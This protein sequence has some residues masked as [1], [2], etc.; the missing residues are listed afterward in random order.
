[1]VDHSRKE[2]TGLFHT[3]D[4]VHAHREGSEAMIA[5]VVRTKAEQVFEGF[6]EFGFQLGED[7]GFGPMEALQVLHPL[8]VT[9]GDPTGVAQDIGDKEDITSFLDNGI[10][11]RGGGTVGCLGQ[12]PALEL[13]GV[14]LGDDSFKS[15]RDEDVTLSSEHFLGIDCFGFREPRHPAG[16]S[17]MLSQLVG[18]E[19]VVI[20]DRSGNIGNPAHFHPIGRHGFDGIGTDIPESLHDG[21]GALN[22]ESGLVEGAGGKEGDAVSRGLGA[23]FTSLKIHGLPGNDFGNKATGVGRIGIED[24]RHVLG[25]GADIGRHDI[26]FRS[27]ERRDFLGKATGQTFL[28]GHAELARVAGDAALAASVGKIHERTFPVHPHRQSGHFANL[29]L[30]VKTNTAFDGATGKV[31]LDTVAEKNLGAT[32]VHV[33][34]QAESQDSFGPFATFPDRLVELE[35]IG[36]AVKLPGGHTED[37]VV[38]EL[39]FHVREDA[40]TV[41]ERAKM[42]LCGN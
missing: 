22:R 9:H 16:F 14:F 18:I 10:G 37:F 38:E 31:M 41:W 5:F 17:D 1:M 21:G 12:D 20:P 8:K 26:D 25:G 23:A 15:S 28:L 11:G 19:T 34:R 42:K 33:N 35:K 36:D 27:D 30:R 4:I 24:P 13:G 7:F 29:D 6:V 32:V 40:T 2:P 39:L 3:G